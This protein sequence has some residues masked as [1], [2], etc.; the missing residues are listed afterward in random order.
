MDGWGL[1]RQKSADAIQH[2]R[3]PFV[4]S[5]YQQ[6]P[7]TT[8]VNLWRG[9]WLAGWPNGQFRSRPPEPG[10][11]AGS[12]TRSCSGSTSPSAT[13]P[14]PAIPYYSALSGKQ[15][16]MA[17]PCT[18]WAWSATGVFIPIPITCKRSSTPACRKAR[19]RLYPTLSPT[20]ATTDPKSGLGFVRKLQTHL[21]KTTGKIATV[22]GRYYAMD[23]DKRWGK[24]PPGL[25]RPCQRRR[26]NGD[27][28]PGRY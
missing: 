17:G 23:R 20:A 7:N 19:K 22:S 1:G 11:P 10:P 2:A 5:L 3:T 8:L 25:R 27:R 6:Y 18:S 24:G 21:D 12:F 14:L 13:A 4:S 15:R 26:C 16:P 9:R 28:P